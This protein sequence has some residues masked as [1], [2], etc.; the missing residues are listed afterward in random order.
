M[1]GCFLSFNFGRNVDLATVK[2]PEVGFFL[3]VA[4]R[5]GFKMICSVTWKIQMVKQL[6]ADKKTKKR[7]FLLLNIPSI[8][9]LK[10][11]ISL[12]KITGSL[13]WRW[14]AGMLQDQTH[15]CGNY[16]R[17]VIYTLV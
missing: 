1:P 6:V 4:A 11:G 2:I 7:S 16:H 8:Q 10:T 14:D 12:V 5:P 13:Q 3:P 17:F 9:V 15:V